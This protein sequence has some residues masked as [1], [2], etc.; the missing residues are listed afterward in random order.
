MKHPALARVFAVVLAILCLLLLSNGLVGLK[1]AAA[2]NMERHAFEEKYAGRIE[3]YLQLDEELSHSISYDEAYAELEKMIEE[4]ESAAAQHRVDTALYSAGKGGSTMGANIIWEYLPEV[5]SARANLAGARAQFDSLEEAYAAVK[6]DIAQIQAQA[7][8][9]AA[10]GSGEYAALAGAIQELAALYAAEP[11]LPEGFVLPED[12]GEAPPQPVEPELAEPAAPEGERPIPPEKPGEDADEETAAAYQEALAAFEET[13]EPWIAYDVARGEYELAWENY[14]LQLAEYEA[15]PARRENYEEAVRQ[16]AE[17]ESAHAAWEAEFRSALE[18]FPLGQSVAV[19]GQLAEDLQTLS[20]RTAEIVN[21]FKAL[22]AAYGSMNM[23][24]ANFGGTELG[25]IDLA[26]L[27]RLAA[28]SEMD[29]SNMTQEQ[30]LDAARTVADALQTLSSSFGEVS[31]A[32]SAVD[33]ILADASAALATAEQALSKAESTMYTELANI[34]YQLGELEKDKERLEQEKAELDEETSALSKRILET[35]EL[36]RLK[37]RHIS[38][39]QLL[40]NVP[41]VKKAFAESG[42]LPGSAAGYLEEYKQETE[43]LLRGKRVINVLALIGGVAGLAGI[44]AA[45]ELIRSR[46]WLL[47]PVLV[48]LGCAAAADAI[49]MQLGL[50]QMYTALFTAIF[51]LIQL[52]ILLPKKKTA[53]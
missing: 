39:K 5:K 53:V 16:Q 51:A 34:W 22:S 15:Y 24:G 11:K 25:G 6:G 30:L 27:Q 17:Y 50:G 41:E 12:P 43:K 14:R 19:L 10:A 1:K 26:T 47:A 21:T 37:N 23:G 7:G 3:N 33:K 29:Y 44:P 35:D 42:D 46:F 40:I 4:H 8:A 38:A 20:A 18:A 49:N 2:E 9:D 52:L 32:F 13:N 36:K 28:L 31:D 48:C 45:Y